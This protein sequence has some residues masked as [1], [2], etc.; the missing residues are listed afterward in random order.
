[1]LRV[2][3]DQVQAGLQWG[4]SAADSQRLFPPAN[5]P[6]PDRR[7]YFFRT[8]MT[9]QDCQ[10]SVLLA[11]DAGVMTGFRLDLEAGPPGRCRDRLA[12]SLKDIYGAPRTY[13]NPQGWGSQANGESLSGPVTWQQWLTNTT[14][15]S[16]SWSEGT[17]FVGSPLGVSF[18]DDRR[19]GCGYEDQVIVTGVRKERAAAQ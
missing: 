1:M 16:M 17:G 12:A 7:F 6:A 19:G 14:C 3:L 4:M 13:T 18:G 2:G 10:Y 11:S 5:A 8:T 15:I 9:E